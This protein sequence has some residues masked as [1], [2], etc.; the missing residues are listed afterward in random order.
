[1]E[2]ASNTIRTLWHGSALSVIRGSLQF[3]F[4][5]HG[6]KIEF[7]T[8]GQLDVP[9]GVHLCDANSVFLNLKF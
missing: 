1:M 3:P 5:R 2:E 9:T 6:H 4:L 7:Y 8:Y